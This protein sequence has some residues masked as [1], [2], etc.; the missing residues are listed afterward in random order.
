M[1][2]SSS[3]ETDR[4]CLSYNSLA[5][6]SFANTSVDPR[7]TVY[8]GFHTRKTVEGIYDEAH[9]ERRRQTIALAVRARKESELFAG[10]T[11]FDYPL[12]G[13]R[14]EAERDEVLRAAAL[15]V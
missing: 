11:A 10:E 12:D 8:F 6:G 2:V 3:A 1:P 15:A 13:E 4:H 14:A 9:I 7:V 5:H